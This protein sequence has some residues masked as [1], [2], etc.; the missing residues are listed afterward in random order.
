[1]H[2]QKVSSF[3]VLNFVATARGWRAWSGAGLG[4]ALLLADASSAFAAGKGG[5]SEPTVVTVDGTVAVAGAVEVVKT[6]VKTP[7]FQSKYR[8]LDFADWTSSISFDIPQ[9]KRLVVETVTFTANIPNGQISAS[10]ALY[11]SAN[12]GHS[13]ALPLQYQGTFG[14]PALLRYVSTQAVTVRVDPQQIG[15]LLVNVDRTNGG[16]GYYTVTIAGYLEDL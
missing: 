6:P 11:D 1:M 14:N 8:V 2:S 4:L 3:P 9:G 16:Q 13:I 12:N 10:M 5:T 15:L 7:Y